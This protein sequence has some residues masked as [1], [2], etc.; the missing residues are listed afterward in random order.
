M[1][2][3]DTE[4]LLA[5]FLKHPSVCTDTRKLKAG[6]LFFALKGGNFNGNAFAQKA[7]EAGA[8]FAIVDEPQYVQAE[9]KRYLWV[10]NVL[11]ALQQLAHAYR[12]RLST[13]ILGLTGSNGK[14]TT[15]ELIAAVLSTEKHIYATAGNY[16]NHIGVPLTLLAIPP[17]AEIAIVE[18]GTN[19]PGDIPALV[20]MAEPDL[21]MITNVGKAHIELLGSQDGIQQEKGALFRFVKAHGKPIFVN[22][23]DP[24]VVAEAHGASHQITYGAEHSQCHGKI[25]EMSLEGMKMEIWH[26]TWGQYADFESK[27]SGA[28][29]FLNILAAISVGV[30]FGVS[31]AGIQAGIRTYQSQNNRSQLVQCGPYQ[32][33]L[34]AYN[35]NPSSM[36]AALEHILSR[37]PEKV[38]VILGD[39]F[40]LG[41]TSLEE[42]RAIGNYLN[43]NPPGVFIG[44]GKDMQA[45]VAAY[46][47][48]KYGYTEAEACGKVLPQLL[49]GMG[50]I[51]IKGSRGM[52]LE[53]L[54]KFIDPT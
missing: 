14:T 13:T 37:H 16:N 27:L 6:D 26:E 20:E 52:A 40:E 47:G 34:D 5:I 31:L 17:D 28:Y 30:H 11:T 42:H 4:A 3:V 1:N 48:K 32:L 51:L 7:L 12:K 54:V 50:R 36:K 15:K 21:G 9:D 41:Q 24:R 43:E 38:A 33:W 2:T 49:K 19:Q 22:E 10:E 25:V 8:A 39:M 46:Q 23:T 53:R 45:A 29:N 35:A 18:M 44:I